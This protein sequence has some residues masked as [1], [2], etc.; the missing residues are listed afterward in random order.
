MSQPTPKDLILN[1]LSVADNGQMEAREAVSACALFGIRANSVRVALVRLSAAGVVEAVERGSYRLGPAAKEWVQEVSRWQHAEARTKPWDGGWLMAYCGALGR[2]DKAATTRRQRA[3][4][5]SGFQPLSRDL[6]VR[7]DNLVDSLAQLTARLQ[8]LGLEPDA[9]V[10]RLCEL[11][12]ARDRDSRGLWEGA[13]LNDQ[14]RDTQQSI[15]RWLQ[16]LPSLGLEDAA[17]ESFLLGKAAIRQMIYDPLLP[18]PLVDVTLRRA[19]QAAVADID[20]AGHEVWRKLRAT[21]FVEG[22]E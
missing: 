18:E 9:L 4:E 12:P 13:A 15:E 1:L 16:K 2:S 8:R 21:H 6:Y 19:C 7:P 17:R 5:L 11:D 10:G 20:R 14:Y 22:A 3:L